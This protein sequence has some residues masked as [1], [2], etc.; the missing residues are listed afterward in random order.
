[1]IQAFVL[2]ALA[3]SSLILSGLLPYVMRIPD[4]VIGI[5]AGVGAGALI[6][7]VAFDLVPEADVLPSVE[8]ALWLLVGATVFIVLDRIVEER[9]GSEGGGGSGGSALGI[10][11]GSV[12]DG[13]PESLIFGIQ[14][15]SGLPI[16]VAFLAAVIVSNIPQALAPSAELK[17]A[18][19]SALK[20]TAMW[21]SVVLA[22]GVAAVVGFAIA[23]NLD[24]ATGARAAALAAGGLLAMLTN[25]LIPFAY[26]K[27]GAPAGFATVIGFGV[28]L[29]MT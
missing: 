7:A 27:G 19:W 23:S 5:L 28:A 16:S 22:C 2:G 10:V 1:V 9:F 11:L 13:V 29:A 14:I 3:Q 21:G 25:S 15:A 6:S 26:E 12:V 18:G 8:S 24:D 4:R 17:T 20:M